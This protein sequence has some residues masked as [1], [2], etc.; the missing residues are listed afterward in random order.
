M[1]KT[2]QTLRDNTYV[3]NLMKTGNEIEEIRKFK[4]EATKIP[5]SAKFSV[6]RCESNILELES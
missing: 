3:D 6:H 2:I 5:E 1:S 4:S